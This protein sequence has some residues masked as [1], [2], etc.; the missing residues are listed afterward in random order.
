MR[1]RTIKPDFFL[2]EDLDEVDERHQKLF[3]GL[4]LLADCEGKLGDAPKK[5]KAQI[6]PYRDYDV[7]EMLAV[8]DRHGFIARYEVAGIHCIK[9]LRFH[10]HQ[11]PHPK[12]AAYGL[13]DPR[14]EIIGREKK[15]PAVKRSVESPL[16]SPQ[17]SRGEGKE[18]RKESLEGKEFAGSASADPPAPSENESVDESSPPQ[19][20]LDGP[21][22]QPPGSEAG[23][24]VSG[25]LPTRLKALTDALCADFEAIRGCKYKHGGAKDTIALKSLLA[26]ATEDE[27]RGEWQEALARPRDDW[28]SCSTFAQL[29]SKWNDLTAPR[30]VRRL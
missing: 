7:D 8:L 10:K 29:S 1:I 15:R 4:W 2:D 25:Y 17:Q 22:Q 5:I 19:L 11:R 24:A 3:I 23:A 18:S 16:P 27:I 14:P 9:V 21:E 26:V 20:A 6:F 13:P 12:E 30:R 28:L